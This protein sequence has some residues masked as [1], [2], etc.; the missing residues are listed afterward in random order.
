MAVWRRDGTTLAPVE[1]E[2][3][4]LQLAHRARSG[5]TTSTSQSRSLAHAHFWTTPEE[6]DERQPLSSDDGGFAL[7]LDGR[8]DN[9][10]E[11]IA[12][13]GG[14]HAGASDAELLLRAFQRWGEACFAKLVGPFA[15]CIF[16]LRRNE[17]VLARDPVGDRTL[18]YHMSEHLLVVAS[19]EAAV[20]AHRDVPRRL[21]ETTLARLYAV[22]APAAGATLFA[23]VHEVPPGHVLVVGAAR[24]HLR[25]FW[26]PAPG[27]PLSIRSDTEFAETFRGLLRTAVISR[28]RS[29]GPVGV[30]MSGGLDSTSV[31]C[32]AAEEVARVGSGAPLQVF[33][34]VFD[35]LGCDE[36]TYMDAVTERHGMEAHRFAGDHFW[37][38]RGALE[39]PSDPSGPGLGPYLLLHEEA[40]RAARD[41]GVNV[42]LTGNFGDNL[43]STARFWLTDLV[44]ERRV[45]DAASG[46]SSCLARLGPA[47]LRRDPG[48]RHL[49]GRALRRVRTPSSPRTP[50]AAKPWLTPTA[51]QAIADLGPS[52]QPPADDALERF[53]RIATAWA[54]YGANLSEA[55]SS[56]FG[57]EV[58]NP[59]RDRRLVEFMAAVP[60][61]QSYRGGLHKHILREA[62]RGIL[63][64]RVR[65]R[66]RA[67][68]YVPLFN[69]GFFEREHAT[70]RA[71]LADP[72]AWWPRFVRRDWLEEA[73]SRP[74]RAR[75]DGPSAVVPWFCVAIEL[76]RRTVPPS[77]AFSLGAP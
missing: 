75:D 50:T 60:G 44:R 37:P 9:R 2:P 28:M 32:L 10:D 41:L 76:W 7:A 33:S 21:D 70:V 46:L 25:R 24:S 39:R 59:Y 63:P 26:S 49:V 19:E 15:V 43:Y 57:I 3:S 67:T 11:L 35:E 27:P 38:L 36:R 5:R 20:L 73:I 6:V 17:T 61:H 14:A 40:W 31:A 62:M 55:S 42:L 72:G 77:E 4:L 65:L 64:E 30:L 71:L 51:C 58:R 54:A 69:R 48:V 66:R 12:A 23:D 47:G 18:C 22:E 45:G 13:L 56:R 53:G 1:L 16:D 34:W 8:L 52:Q 29:P 68:S 74:V